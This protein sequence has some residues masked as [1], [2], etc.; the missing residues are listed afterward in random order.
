MDEHRAGRRVQ[1]GT[2]DGH[3]LVSGVVEV[4]PVE[5]GVGAARGMDFVNRRMLLG[6]KRQVQV[7]RV[8]HKRRWVNLPLSPV[9]QVDD[10][11]QT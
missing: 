10:S 7:G 5:V 4:G 3:H 9:S 8:A 1:Q 6:Q 2:E 11:A